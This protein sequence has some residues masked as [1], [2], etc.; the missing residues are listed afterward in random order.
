[1]PFLVQEKLH[2]SADEA[3]ALVKELEPHVPTFLAQ[4]YPEF[5]KAGAGSVEHA[6]TSEKGAATGMDRANAD[7][8][9]SH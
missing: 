3:E 4:P 2:A 5:A 1:M 9:A 8:T 7:G 6:A